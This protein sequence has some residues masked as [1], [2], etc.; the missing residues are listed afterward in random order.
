MKERTSQN[1]QTREDR[2]QDDIPRA[3]STKGIKAL[4]SSH[5]PSDHP[6]RLLISSEKAELTVEEFRIKLDNWLTLLDYKS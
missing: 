6:L 4:V 5:L 3:I 2:A 1:R